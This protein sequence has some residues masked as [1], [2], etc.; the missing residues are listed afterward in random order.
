MESEEQ[1]GDGPLR[2]G[3][4]PA[5]AAA[6]R[7]HALRSLAGRG[8]PPVAG[9]EDATGDA[10]ALAATRALL[11]VGSRAEA[12]LVLHTAVADL[13]GSVVPARVAGE[14]APSV[15][16]SLGAGEPSVVL[17]AD[18]LDPSSLR[19]T[20][21]LPAL[22]E[23]AAAAAVRCDLRHGPGLL[24]ASEFAE[25]GTPTYDG[26][27]DALSSADAGAAV[28]VLGRALL[29][30]EPPQRLIREVLAAGQRRVGE[31]WAEGEWSVADEHAATSV[32]EQALGLIAPPQRHQPTA[33]RV[34]LAC[35]E[36][37]WH[38]MPARLA[39][40]LARSPRLHIVM[41]GANVPATDLRRHLRATAPAALALSVTMPTNLI[42]AS[43]SIQA[44]RSEGVPVIVGG[45]AWGEGQHRARRLGADLHLADAEELWLVLDD[46][47]DGDD[48]AGPPPPLA[49]DPIPAEA[50]LLDAPDPA[51]LTSALERM[52]AA[53]AWG[54][55]LTPL[56]R[57][58][59]V[60]DLQWLV[61]YTAASIACADPTIVRDHLA[62]L[63]RRRAPTGVPAA[64]AVDSCRY[65]ADEVEHLA[66]RGARALREAAEQAHE[67][68]GE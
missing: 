62:W 33:R 52:S 50:L 1:P 51:L 32:A 65:L 14:S 43:R 63:L 31:L 18:P 21:H 64:A 49:Q 24:G 22:V 40:E 68:A 46:T 67:G 39:A 38:A 30:G 27:L 54:R 36:G 23:D 13:G 34:V 3:P 4:G 45:H 6:G 10:V 61:R 12:A 48:I 26:Y 25:P 53:S 5:S 47:E 44:A 2:G 15:D 60:E 28:S 7:D 17:L 56:Q 19:L 57:D 41:L 66:P 55:S 37:E 35:A 16:V 9:H 8:Y 58:R 42:A 11:Q 20:R 59:V 29:Q